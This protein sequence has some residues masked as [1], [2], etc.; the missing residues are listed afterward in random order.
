MHLKNQ[1]TPILTNNTSQIPTTH[2][3]TQFRD[4]LDSYETNQD[5]QALKKSLTAMG[6]GLPLSCQ[7]LLRTE[8]VGFEPTRVLPLHDFESCAINRTLPPLHMPSG[9]SSLYRPTNHTPASPVIQSAAAS[10]A[11]IIQY[12]AAPAQWQLGIRPS[13]EPPCGRPA[14]ANRKKCLLPQGPRASPKPGGRSHEQRQASLP[15]GNW[16]SPWVAKEAT[17]PRPVAAAGQNRSAVQPTASMDA[18]VL[19]CSPP[20]ADSNSLGEPDVLPILSTAGASVPL[21]LDKPALQQG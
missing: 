2:P 16:A 7:N 14:L 13:G 8:R 10:V 1:T 15:S 11:P 19:R 3:K 17:P 20:A 5:H 6:L 4:I 12:S 21:G 18:A 9:I